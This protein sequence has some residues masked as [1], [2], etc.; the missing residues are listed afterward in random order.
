MAFHPPSY[1]D[2]VTSKYATAMPAEWS[3]IPTAIR[4][5]LSRSRCPRKAGMGA[6][7][8]RAMSASTLA[9]LLCKWIRRRPQRSFR[10][11]PFPRHSTPAIAGRA[12]FSIDDQ[13]RNRNKHTCRWRKQDW[14]LAR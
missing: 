12:A 14:Q 4:Y 9:P 6:C 10:R 3:S 11:A 13:E 8:E 5:F 7:R 2:I 1:D